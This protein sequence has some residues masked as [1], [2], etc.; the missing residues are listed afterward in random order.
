VKYW[1]CEIL[2]MW[3]T[4]HVKYW[5]CEILNMWNTEHVKYW[6]CE[7]L[8]T[9][10]TEHVKYWTC[11]ILNMWNTEHVK[12]WTCEI[13]DLRL[14]IRESHRCPLFKVSIGFKVSY[15]RW[16][17]VTSTNSVKQ[18]YSTGRLIQLAVLFNWPSY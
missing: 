17:V 2:N 3:N 13:Q 11:E 18:S 7:I 15:F 6:T 14:Y 5:T 10:N 12:Y 4:E 8:N 1:T 9:W 16:W